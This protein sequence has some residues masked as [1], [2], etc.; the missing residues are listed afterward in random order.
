[1]HFYSLQYNQNLFT[2]HINDSALNSKMGF[3]IKHPQIHG[4]FCYC[5]TE[6]LDKDQCNAENFMRDIEILPLTN[7][8]CP[9][10]GGRG[11]SVLP[12]LVSFGQNK[13]FDPNVILV[14]KLV[15]DE[16]GD[17]TLRLIQASLNNN[18]RNFT[19]SSISTTGSPARIGKLSNTADDS[20]N[21]EFGNG[22]DVR[23]AFPDINIIQGNYSSTYGASQIECHTFPSLKVSSVP[24]SLGHTVRT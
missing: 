22:I 9:L 12:D 7:N 4:D 1:M 6:R 23:L 10:N 14:T 17:A 15:K 5:S 19:R 8:N 24:I 16:S 3:P 20:I 18:L 2:G 21:N 13:D 11:V